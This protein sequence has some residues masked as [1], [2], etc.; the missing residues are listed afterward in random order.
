MT[1]THTP[2][3]SVSSDGGL[4]IATNASGMPS[5]PTIAK[6]RRRP[7]RVIVRSDHAPTQGSQIIDQILGTKTMTVA[8]AARQ[9]QDLGAEVEQDDGRHRRED[10]GTERA[11]GIR[12]RSTSRQGRRAPAMGRDRRHSRVGWNPNGEPLSDQR[13]ARSR[14]RSRPCNRTWS[15]V[16]RARPFCVRAA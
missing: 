1:P 6:G 9:R 12:G 2:V 3:A 15:S 7:M 5:V 10:A 11:C 16:V 4:N 8:Q 13:R 14:L